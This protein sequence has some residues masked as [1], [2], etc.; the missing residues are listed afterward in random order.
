MQKLFFDQ[1]N[2]FYLSYFKRL[3]SHYVYLV[4][5]FAQFLSPA[6][7]TSIEGDTGNDIRSD[8]RQFSPLSIVSFIVIGPSPGR[9]AKN[10]S[11]WLHKHIKRNG[12]N[13]GNQKI[14]DA[15]SVF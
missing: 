15:A 5:S 9:S 10:V 11:I 8:D 13:A 6:A 3:F 2:K 12:N 7:I 1:P 14:A 4:I